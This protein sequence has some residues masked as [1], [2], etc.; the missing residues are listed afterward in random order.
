MAPLR[1]LIHKLEYCVS[2]NSLILSQ[3]LFRSKSHIP[4]SRN[5]SSAEPARTIQNLSSNGAILV[6]CLDF[7]YTTILENFGYRREL[8]KCLSYIIIW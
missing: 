8:S 7:E 1:T 6:V 4:L 5:T 3:F 2:T